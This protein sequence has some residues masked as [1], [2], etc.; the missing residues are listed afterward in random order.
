MKAKIFR[1]AIQVAFDRLIEGFG[2][3]AIETGEVGVDDDLLLPQGQNERFERRVGLHRV[4]KA[5][6]P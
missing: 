6:A 5:W 4:A 2:R 1:K 3:H